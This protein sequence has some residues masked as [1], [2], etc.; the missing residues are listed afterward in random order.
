MITIKNF[1][2]LLEKTGRT[3][4]KVKYVPHRCLNSY[5]PK[6]VKFGKFRVILSGKY[7]PKE[8]YR[9]TYPV[10]G[11]EIIYTPEVEDFIAVAVLAVKSWFVATFGAF[12]GA[13]LFQFAV[14]GVFALIAWLMRPK[15]PGM[16]S[17]DRS[18]DSAT[19]SWNGIRNETSP[20]A[21]LPV[22]YGEHRVGGPFLSI[23]TETGK[24]YESSW[25]T[26]SLS[27][28]S[29]SGFVNTFRT[30]DSVKGFNITLNKYCVRESTYPSYNYPKI[31]HW[32]TGQN[33]SATLYHLKICEVYF[34]W[35]A[36]DYKIEIK[37]TSSPDYTDYYPIWFAP[38]ENSAN[39]A[40]S[41]VRLQS[42]NSVISLP[43]D[44]YD[45]RITALG[46]NIID[47]PANIKFYSSVTGL[48]YL[49]SETLTD[50]NYLNTL[51]GF[52]GEIEGISNIEINKNALSN[53]YSENTMP[54]PHFRAGQNNQDII[55][56]FNDIHNVY[57]YN[58]KL[59]Y[60]IPITKTTV[61]TDL[62]SFEVQLTFPQGLFQTDA[63]TGAIYAWTVQYRVRWKKHSEESYPGANISEPSI[64]FKTQS[65]FQKTFRVDNLAADQYDIEITRLTADSDFYHIGSVYL[66][67]IDE[68]KYDDLSYPNT[69]LLGLKFLATDRLSGSVPTITSLVKGI[70]VYQPKIMCGGAELG[71]DEYY[72]DGGYKRF[73]DDAEATWDGATWVTKWSANPIWC[74][75]DLLTN[76]RYGAGNFIEASHIDDTLLVEMANYCDELVPVEEGSEG[77]E[78]RFRLDVVLDTASRVPDIMNGL[79]VSFR[80]NPFYSAGKIKLQIDKAETPTQLFTMGNIID[81]SFSESFS[82]LK[83]IFNMVEIQFA[84]KD[85]NYERDTRGISDDASLIAGEPLRRKQFGL[86]GIARESQAMRMGK[87]FLNLSKY[88]TRMI[89]FK[90]GI[91][92]IACQVGDVINFQHDVP[93]W[94]YGGRIVSATINTITL[95]RKVKVETGKT[96][97][98]QVRLADGTIEEKTVTDG[99]GE[100]ETLNVTPDFSAIPPA[101]GLYSFGEIT[102]VTKPFRII[103][104]SKDDKDEVSVS[105]IEYNESIY[106]DITGVHL[107]TPIYSMLPAPNPLVE[108][109][110]LTEALVKMKDGTIEDA[111][112]ISFNRPDESEFS[113]VSYDHANIYISDDEGASWTF[114]GSTTGEFFQILGGIADL[115]TYYVAVTSVDRDG[116]ESKI[117]ESPQA[118]IYVQGKTKPPAA[119]TN[120]AVVQSGDRLIFTWDKNIE[121]DFWRYEIREGTSWGSSMFIAAPMDNKYDLLNFT[122]GTKIYWIKAVD[123]SGNYSNEATMDSIT[124]TEIPHKNY[125]LEFTDDLVGYIDAG[126]QRNQR[127]DYTKGT[128]VPTIE[129]KTQK[130]WDTMGKT[131]AQAETDKDRWDVPVVVQGSYISRVIDLGYEATACVNLTASYWGSGEGISQDFQERHK[132]ETGDWTEWKSFWSGEFTFR[133]LQIKV[134][135]TTTNEWSRVRLLSLKIF[136]DV[137]DKNLE[138]LNRT[139]ASTGTII[140]YADEGVDFQRV[141]SIVVTTVGSSPLIPLI[142]AQ[143]NDECTIRLFDVDGVAQPGAVNV[144]C[145]GY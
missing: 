134:I 95:D 133:Y 18:T 26:L 11:D 51:I 125:I 112:N 103:D 136:V 80:C 98:V 63:S 61:N 62:Q 3:E 85:R 145:Y 14:A 60:G 90:A 34:G 120:F 132:T 121:V 20:D 96:Y 86:F 127:E 41:S 92:S 119:V 55:E 43:L 45:V 15:M 28:E 56:G 50:L 94:G 32:F 110:A 48:R 38:Y 108:D 31:G 114:R 141:K 115:K 52:E 144:S 25:R 117:S 64:S 106:D 104:F 138:I 68:I 76:K 21:V 77:K 102:K 140:V 30:V 47:A 57:S 93:V 82:P 111:I 53:Y 23:F 142:T 122:K 29:Q 66:T 79:A 99:A 6:P 35:Y 74:I 81:D 5:L 36:L 24:Q 1:P 83:T 139:I 71:Y 9:K 33:T 49:P 118:N 22:I 89:G 131:W 44:F 126:L 113:Y 70:K 72:Y 58:D 10:D 46:D 97:K 2:S 124:I 73:P 17:I 16:T 87:Y 100:Y 109:L 59:N 107:P 75:R 137:P 130:R 78:K 40:F 129:L 12:W 116:S 65:S 101:W 128:F 91:D 69:A 42:D 88:C 143:S 84:N 8:L 54:I 19:Y 4:K 135:L 39:I 13:V 27:N 123:T 67:Q 105:A 37:K 7:I